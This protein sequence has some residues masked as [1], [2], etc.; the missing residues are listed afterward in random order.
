MNFWSS[1]INIQVH[2]EIHNKTNICDVSIHLRGSDGVKHR[3]EETFPCAPY[4]R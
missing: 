1:I 4:I 2:F 3:I